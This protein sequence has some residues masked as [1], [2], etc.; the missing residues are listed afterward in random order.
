MLIHSKQF[1]TNVPKESIQPNAVDITLDQVFR[2]LDVEVKISK[3]SAMMRDRKV[4][5]PSHSSYGIET[6]PY[7]KFKPGQ[8][9][10]ESNIGCDLPQGVVGWIVARSTL[11][12]NGIFIVSG[13]YD[14]G[15][16]ST[17]IGGTMYIPCDVEIEQGA[18]IAQFVTMKAE[19]EYLYNGKYQGK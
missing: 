3:D 1:C 4:M 19:T 9:Q 8:Y 13:I 18:R 11:N 2:L 10:F 12:R 14:A 6:A 16:H 7:Y 17:T 5:H 15:F